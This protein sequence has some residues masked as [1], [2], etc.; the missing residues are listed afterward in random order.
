MTV[1]TNIAAE[2]LLGAA[3]AL[4]PDIVALR[5]AIHADPEL[6][7][8]NPRTTRRILDALAGL[9]LE[10]RQGPSTTGIIAI[11]EGTA[12]SDGPK[13]SVKCANPAV[14]SAERS[15]PAAHPVSRHHS[16]SPFGWRPSSGW[17]SPIASRTPSGRT[18][19]PRARR[20]AS[21]AVPS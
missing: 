2:A 6:G 19:A 1:H 14:S 16:D 13:R 17:P 12:P 8:H 21:S 10:I 20:S 9:P 15:V 5:R 4:M 18:S 11:L 3:D 7:L